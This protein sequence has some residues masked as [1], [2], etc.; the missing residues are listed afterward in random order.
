MDLGTP[1]P[2]SSQER[3]IGTECTDRF[4]SPDPSS[5]MVEN[6]EAPAPV[7]PADLR[8][9]QVNSAVR[10]LAAGTVAEKRAGVGEFF[11]DTL[12]IKEFVF[13]RIHG[14][15]SLFTGIIVV[16]QKPVIA[17]CLLYD[18]NVPQVTAA[19]AALETFKGQMGSS[20]Y[21]MLCQIASTNSRAIR[22]I[23]THSRKFECWIRTSSDSIE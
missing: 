13:F 4:D 23:I 10:Q 5:G 6:E 7:I 18:V 17:I 3:I 14:N 2:D 22:I 8:P 1:I 9:G 20:P 16:N 19:F 21:R 15:R 12:V 11:K